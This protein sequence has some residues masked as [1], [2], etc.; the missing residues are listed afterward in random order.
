MVRLEEKQDVPLVLTNDGA[1]KIRGSRVTLDSIIYSF[2]QGDTPV[3]IQEAFPTLSLGDVFGAIY[4]FLEHTDV[5]EEY[6]R[7]R[8]K[9]GEETRRII[10]SQTDNPVL[11]ERIREHRNRLVKQ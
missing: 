7:N 1:I 11:S 5:I 10:E 8:E 9:E 3:Q 4:Y 6:L 2:K